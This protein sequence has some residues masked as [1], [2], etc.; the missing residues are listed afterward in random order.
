MWIFDPDKNRA[1]DVFYNL[2]QNPVPVTRG[3]F[4]VWWTFCQVRAAVKVRGR[5]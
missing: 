4:D 1:P 3:E 5:G 2:Q